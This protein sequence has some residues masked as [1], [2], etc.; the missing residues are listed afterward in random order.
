MSC[1]N[2]IA[3]F[4][5]SLNNKGSLRENFI[6][7]EN[8]LF[9]I[10]WWFFHN[11]LW[12]KIR[13]NADLGGETNCGIRNHR[14]TSWHSWAVFSVDCFDVLHPQKG[15]WIRLFK[16]VILSCQNLK[17]IFRHDLSNESNRFLNLLQKKESRD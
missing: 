6:F 1:H 14:I 17:T 7:N 9:S 15:P 13:Y 2:K 16:K 10:K 5:I 4:L 11:D 8:Q 12:I 3:S